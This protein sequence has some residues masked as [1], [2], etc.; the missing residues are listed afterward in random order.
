MSATEH[1]DYLPPRLLFNR[2]LET[3]YPALMRK[4]NHDICERLEVETPDDDFL[5]LDL[6]QGHSA[7]KVVI[8]SH[9]LEG[10]ST[11]P[12]VKGMARAFNLAGWD[13]IAWNYRGCGS[14]L[15]RQKIFYHSGA[16]YDLEHIV[17][18]AGHRYKNAFLVGFSL[19]GNLTL[20]YL[21]EQGA[22]VPEFIMGA[23]VYSVPM[24]LLSCSRELERRHNYMYKM[25]FLNNLKRKVLAK[26]HLLESEFPLAHLPKIRT[27]F[28]FDDVFTAPL[29]GFAHANDYYEQCSAVRYIEAMRVP[30]LTINARND[31]FLTPL[32]YP[33]DIARSHNYLHLEIPDRGGHVGFAV[34]KNKIYWSEKRAVDF[35]KNLY[36]KRIQD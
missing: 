15:N 23:C 29:H 21:G 32:C 24:D 30:V 36:L 13:V 26:A 19:G 27:I 34:W 12:Y 2:H 3:I 1:I 7:D 22:N 4:V 17:D 11:R 5:E 33:T 14:R 31:P 9:G 10:S 25:R 35:A 6:Y 28:E 16:T 8:I 18:F 20:K